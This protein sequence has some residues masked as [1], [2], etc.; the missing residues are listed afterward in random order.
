LSVSLE[1]RFGFIQ[2]I[3]I[4]ASGLYEPRYD[5]LHEL[6]GGPQAECGP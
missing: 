1:S 5:G 3:G 6:V 2:Q 4:S